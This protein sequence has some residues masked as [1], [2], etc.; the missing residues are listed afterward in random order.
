MDLLDSCK[1]LVEKA[2]ELGADAC[3]AYGI[4]VETIRIV[5]EKG[6]IKT[7]KQ[8]HDVGVGIRTIAKGSMGYS[9]TASLDVELSSIAQ[10]AVKAAK[11]GPPDPDFKDLPRPSSYTSP[12]LTYD[13]QVASLTPEELIGLCSSLAEKV[14][15]KSIYSINMTIEASTF[16]CYI[17]NSNGVEGIDEGT[18]IYFGVYA[19]AKDGTNMS[20]SYEA[21]AA[22]SLGDIN[23]EDMTL[24]ASEE[25]IKGL[26]AKTYKTTKT[27]VIFAE[28][29]LLAII[30]EGI[31]SALNADLIQRGRS[32]LTPKLSSK[33]AIDELTIIDDGLMDKGLMT[34]KFDVEG[35]PKQ[36]NT[37]IEKGFIKS[38]LHNS[39][40]A[41]KANTLSTGNATRSGGDLDFRGQVTIA[42]SNIVVK[43]GDWSLEEMV[44]EVKNGLLILNTDDRPN[45]ATGD[46]SAMITHGYMI[47]NGEVTSPVKQTLFAIN[48]ID[49]M[50]NIRGIG[51]EL[52][53]HF[54]LYAPPILVS[55]V[56]ISSKA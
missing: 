44:K 7:A 46:L 31:A 48:L 47:E 53:K 39:Y 28:K 25:A 13:P 15:S 3:D 38:L 8:I 27:Q 6:S 54:N 21:D 24:K 5:L 29:V 56:Q 2:V 4:D 14:E 41:G 22:R 51:K 45:M 30:A 55:N 10:R 17:A 35:T 19:T 26:K 23:F 9:Y 37:L 52:N 32:F 34:R 18:C 16:K 50:Q 43:P 20:S 12:Q 1:K 33:V 36:K 11:A 42:P 49:M 40:T